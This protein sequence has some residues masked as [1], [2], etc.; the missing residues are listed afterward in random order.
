MDICFRTSKLKKELCEEKK[1][2]RVYGP[3]RAELIKRRLAEIEAAPTLAV[4]RTIP[5][6]RC[7]ELKGGLK[8]HLSVDLDHPFRLIF[9][10]DHNPIPQLVS[11][12]MNWSQITAVMIHEVTNTHE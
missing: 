3:R 10:P 12:G 11:G 2:R 5:G 9:V 6:P 1:L 7:H 4:L 8:G